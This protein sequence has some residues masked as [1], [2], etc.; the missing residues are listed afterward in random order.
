M[1][2]YILFFLILIM[3]TV[4]LIKLKVHDK[5]ANKTEKFVRENLTDNNEKGIE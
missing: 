4:V 1:V 5:V 2:F 3:I